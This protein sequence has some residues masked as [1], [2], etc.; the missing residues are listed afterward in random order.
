MRTIIYT[1]VSSTQQSTDDKVSLDQQTDQCLVYAATK[2]YEVVDV[3]R[4]VKSA[5]TVRERPVLLDTMRRIKDG[6]A[7]V[8]LAY[9][10]DRLTRQQSGIYTIDETIR[11]TGRIEF[12]TEEFEDTAIGR[13]TRSAKAFVAEAELEKIAI[14]SAMG[15]QGRVSQ[16]RLLVSANARFGYRYSGE[17]KERYE[18]DEVQAPIIKR[19]FAD[20]AAGKSLTRLVAELNDKG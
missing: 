16:G 12:A 19:I 14:R 10:L 6:E 15:R 3:V 17:K 20:F 7:D 13:F 1:R 9:C 11:D 5:G 4:E 18:V 8:L 2:G